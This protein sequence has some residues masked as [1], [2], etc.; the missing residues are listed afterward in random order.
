MTQKRIAL[1]AAL[2][3][4]ALAPAAEAGG[5]VRLGFGGPLGTFVATPSRGAAAPS[6]TVNKPARRKAPVVQAARRP[7]KPIRRVEVSPPKWE[8]KAPQ[9]KA[10]P[11]AASPSETT[12]AAS[13]PETPMAPAQTGSSAL[14]QGEIAAEPAREAAPEEASQ[15]TALVATPD[16]P[17]KAADEAASKES[18]CKKFIPAVGMTVSVGCPE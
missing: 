18:E 13:T 14:I 15:T 17:A 5:G 9:A 7:E 1:A 10:V 4:M 11:A 8:R 6:A 12:A 3:V 2:A 16:A